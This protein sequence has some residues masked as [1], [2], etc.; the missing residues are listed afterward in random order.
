MHA[1]IKTFFPLILNHPTN[2][3]QRGI[4]E[5]G[6]YSVYKSFSITRDP[7]ISVAVIK[8]INNI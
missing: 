6:P 5:N 7:G 8:K 2:S 4:K 3:N 1:V